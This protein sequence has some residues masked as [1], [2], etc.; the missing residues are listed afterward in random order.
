MKNVLL[1]CCCDA[2]APL[3]ILFPC[4]LLSYNFCVSFAL[5]APP[6]LHVALSVLLVKE[7]LG[8]QGERG[9]V[10]MKRASYNSTEIAVGIAAGMKEAVFKNIE[11]AAYTS[12]TQKLLQG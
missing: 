9:R 4:L 8:A 10:G 12:R 2:V 1:Q 6:Q 5:I 3:F 11:I 7:S